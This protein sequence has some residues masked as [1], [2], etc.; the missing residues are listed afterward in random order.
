[1]R[2]TK[3]MEDEI[4]DLKSVSGRYTNN[5]EKSNSCK[6]N[7]ILRL[8]ILLITLNIN[9]IELIPSSQPKIVPLIKKKLTNLKIF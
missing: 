1:M 8:I 2:K 3:K 7:I 5:N 9:F 6:N 4:I